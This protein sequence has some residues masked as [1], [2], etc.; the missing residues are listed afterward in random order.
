MIEWM[1][2]AAVP[3]MS[4]VIL[5]FIGS[6]FLTGQGQGGKERFVGKIETSTSIWCARS[7]LG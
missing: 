1:R 3:I 5:T 2:K 6:M 4:I 7:G